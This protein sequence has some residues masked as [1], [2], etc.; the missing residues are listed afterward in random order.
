MAVAK[1]HMPVSWSEANFDAGAVADLAIA[2]QE[3][4]KLTEA[5][6]LFYKV[7]KWYQ[8]IY[9]PNHVDTATTQNNIG[10]MLQKQDKYLEVLEMYNKCLKT[11]E[12]VLGC[13]HLHVA[14]T[15]V[16]QDLHVFMSTIAC[17]AAEKHWHC[18]GTAGQA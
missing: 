14:D 16:W 7:L 9:S 12:K 17:P 4:R 5:L 11:H 13:N 1:A 2:L 18:P 3:Q 10:V 15:K 8:R 6:R